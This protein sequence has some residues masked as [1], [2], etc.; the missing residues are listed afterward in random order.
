MELGLN[1]ANSLDSF[2]QN[3]N[4]SLC[5]GY[6]RQPFRGLKL[7]NV[8]YMLEYDIIRH[9]ENALLALKII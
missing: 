8:N 3:F 7:F 2:L 5:V 4:Y 1:G 6:M 9:L